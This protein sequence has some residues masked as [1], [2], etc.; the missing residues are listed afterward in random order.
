ML[1]QLLVPAT[2]SHP[3]YQRGKTA[4]K[5]QFLSLE[6][7]QGPSFICHTPT[8]KGWMVQLYRSIRSIVLLRA[9]TVAI[10]LRA[11]SW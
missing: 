2:W 10:T 5:S 4:R 8:Q 3:P 6:V 1:R 9:A 11:I 7:G